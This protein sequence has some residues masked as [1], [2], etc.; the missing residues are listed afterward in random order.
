MK[1]AI[2]PLFALACI[3]AALI[4]P[5]E[6]HA[7]SF[8]RGEALQHNLSVCLNKADAIELLDVWAKDGFDASMKVWNAK[9]KCAPI[10]VVGGIVGKVVHTVKAE[11]GGEKLTIVAVEILTPDGKEVAAY[12]MTSASVSAVSGDKLGDPKTR[13]NS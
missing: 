1:R 13:Q 12:F 11:R 9:D 5:R 10:N 4:G 2:Q 6:A 7:L 3:L 8:S